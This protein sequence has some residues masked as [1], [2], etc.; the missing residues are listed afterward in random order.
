MPS[1]ALYLI[2]DGDGIPP[3][4]SYTTDTTPTLAWGASGGTIFTVN[5]SSG[6]TFITSGTVVDTQFTLVDGVNIGDYAANLSVKDASG[7]VLVSASG[8]FHILAWL[9]GARV[10]PTTDIVLAN[11]Q[12]PNYIR[13]FPQWMSIQRG[14]PVSGSLLYR[15]FLPF[16]ANVGETSDN[17]NTVLSQGSILTT[18]V[19]LPRL[20]W[21]LTTQFSPR[22]HVTARLSASGTTRE[23]RQVSTLHEFFTSED[24]V[25]LL[26][27][28]GHMGFRNLALRSVSVPPLA[29]SGTLATQYWIPY[30]GKGIVPDTDVL[31]G[32]PTSGTMYRIPAGSP[33][34]D[35]DRAVIQ[36]SSPFSGT[37][38]FQYH[39]KTLLDAITVTV[40][41]G[42]STAPSQSDLW[43]RFDE[44]GLL[45]G[46]RRKFGEDNL[47]LRRRLY[48]RLISDIGTNARP[49]AQHIAQD[50]TLTDVLPWNGLTTL[51]LS[52]SGYY[53][54]RRIDVIG[55]TEI[56]TQAERLVPDAG[57][58]TSGAFIFYGSKT[59][60]LPGASVLVDGTVITALSYPNTAV[61]GNSVTFFQSVGPISGMVHATYRYRN[62][63]S[64]LS[65]LGFITRVV[66]VSGNMVSGDYRVI[67][68]RNVRVFSPSD[69]SYQRDFLLNANGTPNGDFLS[70][71]DKVIEGTLTHFGRSRWG[72]AYWFPETE[73]LP[74]IEHLPVPW[75][76]SSFDDCSEQSTTYP[77]PIP[78]QDLFLSPLAASWS[79]IDPSLSGGLFDNMMWWFESE[80]LSGTLVDGAQI[81]GWVDLS[82]NGIDMQFPGTNGGTRP[83]YKTSIFGS[84]P[85]VRVSAGNQG[86]IPYPNLTPII[87]GAAGTFYHVVE[88][89]AQQSGGAVLMQ[90]FLTGQPATIGL[91]GSADLVDL[92]NQQ[93]NQV[94]YEVTRVAAPSTVDKDFVNAHSGRQLLAF[95]FNTQ[96]GSAT[97]HWNGQLV[98]NSA[99]PSISGGFSF[100]QDFIEFLANNGGTNACS[101]EHAAIVGFAMTHPTSV[102]QYWENY[103]MTKYSVTDAEFVKAPSG[104]VAG[105][106]GTS[107]IGLY[108]TDNSDNEDGFLIER[109]LS[110]SSGFAQVAAPVSGITSYLDTGLSSGTTYY[111]RV[112]AQTGPIPIYSSYSAT[113][114]ATTTS[115][116]FDPYTLGNQL[117]MLESTGIPA[118]SDD[119]DLTTWPDDSTNPANGNDITFPS[120]AEGGNKPRYR[121]NHF[122]TLAG[123]QV[124]SGDEGEMTAFSP[125][126]TAQSA[127]CYFVLDY[128]RADIGT[129]EPG[130]MFYTI[131]VLTNA[132]NDVGC[133]VANDSSPRK[134]GIVQSGG[135]LFDIANSADG[136]QLLTFKLNK[137]A[138]SAT[139]YRN[140]TSVGTVTGLGTAGWDFN[141]N[142]DWFAII[143][144]TLDRFVGYIGASFAF[145]TV[146]DD[147]TRTNVEGYL[148]TKYGI[149]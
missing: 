5:V 53:G 47:S 112:R 85:S 80:S 89:N 60:W 103:L 42:I 66:P 144:G 13:Y 10:Y 95:T 67:L 18:P 70:L 1:E 55:V 12:D 26:G 58:S 92:G 14:V 69:P 119:T 9:R 73:F 2:E 136:K 100:G 48:S 134:D 88:Y 113:A 23:I 141:G 43:N 38:I 79:P 6:T 30:E 82:P 115:G 46:I 98:S 86:D 4:G 19:N 56:G 101:G 83:V 133:Y 72:T 77:I 61:S 75:D 117:W 35:A 111:Y 76:I 50:L 21:H 145:N 52:T 33:A 39:S 138:G 37:I 139:L 57:W 59:D 28:T 90:N 87:S 34:I 24:A 25:F 41:G 127:T 84:M 130:L 110:P 45:A 49:I 143:G 148:M 128:Q 142:I 68:T 126:L 105:A 15:F 94:S 93:F 29:S 107:S 102:R 36:L 96:T 65:T 63:T 17:S 71:R 40:S 78:P 131:D 44:M 62:Y 97:L 74:P 20:W 114:S 118:Q 106:S 104:L 32:Y 51:D 121:T 129:G 140:G 8:T 123:I 147:A 137:A 120:P 146:H 64:D 27:D 81:S 16:L 149:P 99:I 54:V 3:S 91:A 7:N 124:R 11:R 22:D 31:F 125:S 132:G 116:A 109:S 108:W 135:S 122:G